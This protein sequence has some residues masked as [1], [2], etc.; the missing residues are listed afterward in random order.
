M[1]H[2]QDAVFPSTFPSRTL[3][4]VVPYTPGTG[5]DILSRI[6]GPRLAERWKTSVVFQTTV[7]QESLRLQ[8]PKYWP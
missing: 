1:A 8:R 2:A 6:L 5:A 4:I 3:Q 7:G